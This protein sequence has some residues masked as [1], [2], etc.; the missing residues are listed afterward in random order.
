M[1]K[2]SSLGDVYYG[3]LKLYISTQFY[4]VFFSS[5]DD[6]HGGKKRSSNCLLCY[7]I[8]TTFYDGAESATWNWCLHSKLAIAHDDIDR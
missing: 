5:Y 7:H 8:F 3:E 2:Y 4:N 6:N 1:K